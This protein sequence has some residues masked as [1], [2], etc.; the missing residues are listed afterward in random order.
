MLFVVLDDEMMAWRSRWVQK[1][2]DLQ[3]GE[4]VA[5]KKIKMENETEGVRLRAFISPASSFFTNN[6]FSKSHE[7]AQQA[8]LPLPS[9]TA[10][11][12]LQAPFLAYTSSSP[13]RLHLIS[14]H[15]PRSYF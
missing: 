13:P 2:K 5:L 11:S 7:E 14:L 1:A 12:D 9:Q 15:T 6:L 10:L 8:R 3:T 4:V